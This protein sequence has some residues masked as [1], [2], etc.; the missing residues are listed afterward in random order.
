MAA[1]SPARAY[2]RARS[3][4][5]REMFRQPAACSRVRSL[6]K[7]LSWQVIRKFADYFEGRLE[8]SRSQLLTSKA[9]TS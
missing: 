3:A 1:Y 9:R 2:R 6:K 4:V 5:A 7:R 8:C